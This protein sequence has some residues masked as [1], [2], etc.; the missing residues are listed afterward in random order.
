MNLLILSYV[1]P[2][3]HHS[4]SFRFV[5]TQYICQY[6]LIMILNRMKKKFGNRPF[7]EKRFFPE[8]IKDWISSL[9]SDTGYLAL[10]CV[11]L[12]VAQISMTSSIYFTLCIAG[13]RYT[14]VCHPWYKVCSRRRTKWEK[15][16][17]K[18]SWI[19]TFWLPGID[20]MLQPR[21][22]TSGNCLESKFE[23]KL[24]KSNY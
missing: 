19:N 18:K 12:P 4:D 2:L 8:T 14:T 6:W 20:L 23:I 24:K 13:E 7:P 5:S 21:H 22:H 3:Y 1:S 16:R 10:V 9:L 17:E 15:W 11:V